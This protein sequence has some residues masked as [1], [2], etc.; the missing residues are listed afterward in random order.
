MCCRR[1]DMTWENL[2]VAE[3][4][5]IYLDTYRCDT[6]DYFFGMAERVELGGNDM[7]DEVKMIPIAADSR[8]ESAPP[9]PEEIRGD[10]PKHQESGLEDADYRSAC[11]RR[12]NRRGRN[13]TWSAAKGGWKRSSRSAIKEIPAMVVEISKEER[14]IR[15]LVENMARRYPAPMDLIREI[16]RLRADGYNNH[17]IS[18]KLDISD[19]M[20]SGLMSLKKAGEGRL[21]HAALAGKIPLW[22]A[23]GHCQSGHAGDAARTAESL[24]GQT[25]ELYVPAHGQATDGKTAVAGQTKQRWPAQQPN[26]RRNDCGQLTAKK[27]SA[28]N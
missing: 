7:N 26:Q 10:C 23:I 22:V 17:Q 1:I 13:M 14:L 6:L 21:L 3:A 25:T 5:G 8:F 18:E 9:G 12:T 16:E 4:N 20:V 15:S 2:R 24:R 28:R 27:P 19:T 11:G